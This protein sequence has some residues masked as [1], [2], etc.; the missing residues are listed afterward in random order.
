MSSQI[1]SVNSTPR[2]ISQQPVSA[3]N[4]SRDR[5]PVNARLRPEAAN[6]STKPTFPGPA[7]TIQACYL[8]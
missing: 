2:L 1:L 5:G 8:S 3:R 7:M 6:R 4:P